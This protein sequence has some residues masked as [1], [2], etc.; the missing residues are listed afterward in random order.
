MS[1]IE[2]TLQ[3]KPAD[4]GEKANAEPVEH[5]ECVEH[6]G[7]DHPG[8]EDEELEEVCQQSPATEQ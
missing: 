3:E 1:A 4:G 2:Q 8:G 5:K 7:E 6:R